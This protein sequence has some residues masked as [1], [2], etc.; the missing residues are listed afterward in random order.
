MQKVAVG[1]VC[2]PRSPQQSPLW[3]L[4]YDHYHDFEMHYDE[5]SVRCFGYPRRVVGDVITDYHY[6]PV[7][8][9]RNDV[10]C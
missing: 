2:H 9:S 7:K 5:R 3:Q 8:K 4:L 10:S 6:C 1:S